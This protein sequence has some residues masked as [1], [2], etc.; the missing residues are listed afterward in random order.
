MNYKAII[1][2]LDN[3]LLNYTISELKSMQHTVQEHGLIHQETFVWDTFWALFGRHNWQ[4]WSN[5][6]QYGYSINQVLEF[7]FR[8]TLQELGL[9]EADSK[10]LADLYWKAFCNSCDFEAHAAETLNALHGSF[11]LAIISNGIGAA[12]RSRLAAG[13]IDHYFDTLVISDEVGYWK[14]DKEIFDETLQRL[15]IKHTEALFIGDSLQDDYRG[16][17]NAGIDFCYYNPKGN[18]IEKNIMPKYMVPSLNQISGLL[19]R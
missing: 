5:R 2:D 15:H 13:G 12:Q 7:S 11:K 10:V 8:D 3:T 16:A 14:P 1:F 18:P 19:G 4:Y 17:L 6:V 9:H